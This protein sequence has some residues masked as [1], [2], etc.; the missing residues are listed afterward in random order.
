MSTTE[1]KLRWPTAAGIA[2][3]MIAT[4]PLALSFVPFGVAFGIAAAEKGIDPITATLWSA[5]VCGGASQF[6]ALEVWANPL[7]VLLITLTVLMVNSRHVLYG[8]VLYRHLAQM[9]PVPRYSLLGFMTDSCFAY[10]VGIDREGRSADRDDIGLMMGGG[11]IVYLGWPIA[12]FLGAT[13]GALIGSGKAFGLDVVMV[14]YF[15]ASL[16]G[17]W[18]GRSDA[19]PWIAAFLGTL[20]GLWLLPVGWH[21]MA[22]ALSGGAAAL[23]ADAD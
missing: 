12:T 8:A 19:V 22:G 7:P 18:R 10:S 21:I 1:G 14:A 16:A 9:H 23:I 20:A 17:M 5:L 2:Q 15:S 13:L 4:A 11:L 3:G 6:A